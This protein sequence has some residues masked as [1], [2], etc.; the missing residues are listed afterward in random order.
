MTASPPYNFFRRRHQPR[1]CCAV[2]QDRLVPSFIHGAAWDFG[3][4]IACTRSQP[5][6]FR[7]EAAHEA[8]RFTGYYLFQP[9]HDRVSLA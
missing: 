9:L 7:P 1:L 2:R 3:G 6:G 5:S 8:T 4:T